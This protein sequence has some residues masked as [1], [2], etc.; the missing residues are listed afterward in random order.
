MEHKQIC[1]LG[2]TMIFD[3]P[4]SKKYSLQYQVYTAVVQI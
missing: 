3:T 1:L 4:I 2:R